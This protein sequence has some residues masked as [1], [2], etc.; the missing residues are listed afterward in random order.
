MMN[1]EIMYSSSHSQAEI[2]VLGFKGIGF[3]SSDYLDVSL[4]VRETHPQMVTTGEKGLNG[5]DTDRLFRG[6]R[7]CDTKQ[8][9]SPHRAR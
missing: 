7:T 4:S 8:Q 2:S 3:V 1:P 6:R 9:I 5:R